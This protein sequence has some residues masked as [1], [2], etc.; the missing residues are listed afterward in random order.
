MFDPRCPCSHFEF[1]LTKNE[2]DPN[3]LGGIILAEKHMDCA[4]AASPSAVDTFSNGTFA[5]SKLTPI[6]VPNRH[7]IEVTGLP[8]GEIFADA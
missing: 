7:N 4:S 8:D 1:K 2:Q 3:T 5:R 6:L